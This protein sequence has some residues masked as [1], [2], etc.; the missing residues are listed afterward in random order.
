MMVRLSYSPPNIHPFSPAF[1]VCFLGDSHPDW[2]EM[3][4]Q[5]NFDL[6]F[7]KGIDLFV[8]VVVYLLA[9]YSSLENNSFAHLLIVLFVQLFESFIYSG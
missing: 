5:R 7:P 1:V 3:E 8:V 9:I 2:G 4:S 6:H